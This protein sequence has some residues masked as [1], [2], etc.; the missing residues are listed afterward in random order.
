MDHFSVT[1][2]QVLPILLLI[3]L[4]NQLRKRQWIKESTVED[5]KWLAVNIALPSVLFTSFLNL[6]LKISY[7]AVMGVIFGLCV[8]M[9]GLGWG[10]QRLFK[11]N[12]PYFPLLVT[13]FEFGMLG[14]SLFGTSYGMEAIGYIA[15]IGLGH[16]FFIWFPFLSI[17][18]IKRDN[19]RDV[20]KLATAFLKAPPIIAIMLGVALNLLG[21]REPLYAWP[22]MGGAMATL[23]FTGQMT[24]PLILI[25]VGYGFR[26]EA[27][28][29]R[30]VL[31]TVAFRMVCLIPLALML[32]AWFLRDMLH[33][34]PAFQAGLF[35]MLILPPP[36]IVPL[37]MRP[38]D[39][40]E[41]RYVNNVLTV[42]TVVSLAVFVVYLTFNPTL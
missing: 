9:Y 38:E 30:D 29:L 5:L 14:V 4:G 11:I 21:A 28:G 22:V 19:V 31:A 33:L 16:E 6:E 35:T 10:V 18:L 25:I 13:G 12:H 27:H 1:L 15:V 34:H 36:F 3:I 41:R 23:K 32:N 24:I 17:L 40:E 7:L 42:N 20:T 26:L 39:R 2:N 37:F 8:V